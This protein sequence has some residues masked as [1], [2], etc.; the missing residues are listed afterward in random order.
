MIHSKVRFFRGIVLSFG[1][2]LMLNACGSQF[3]RA[4][5]PVAA[6]EPL[7][8]Y[9]TNPESPT[10]KEYIG[11]LDEALAADIDHA[12]LAVDVAATR[13]NLPSLCDALIHAHQRGVV[14][15]ML[16][17]P[18]QMDTVDVQKLIDAEIPVVAAPGAGRMDDNFVILD[19][20][21]VWTGSMIFTTSG[22]Y[23]DESNLIRISSVQAATEYSAQ[24]ERLLTNIPLNPGAATAT[25]APTQTVVANPLEIYFSPSDGIDPHLQDLLL[26]AKESIYFLAYS[27]TS[28][29]LGD[30]LLA[31]AKAGIIVAGVMD[32]G[33]ILSNQGTQFD[34]FTQAGLEVRKNGNPGLLHDLFFVIDHSI[35]VDGSYEFNAGGEN[36]VEENT[37]II[38][39][40]ALA[41]Q[42]IAEYQ[43]IYSQAQP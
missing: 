37:V 18:D 25:Q 15:R 43:R 38:S 9:F 5:S 3:T 8:V 23:E 22:V 7:Q 20:K 28:N 2:G 34:R 27:F 35:V 19:D 26:G 29:D 33:Q 16:M 4:A 24:F 39:N 14:V 31:R 36:P 42:F 13:L 17:A 32:S 41:A 11:G 40:P 21:V 30:A 6:V 12:R 10:A 1:I